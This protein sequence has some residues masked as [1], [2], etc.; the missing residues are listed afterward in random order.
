MLK[1]TVIRDTKST[2]RSKYQ[3]IY[4]QRLLQFDNINKFLDIFRLCNMSKY[5]EIQDA[6]V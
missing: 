5:F 4:S 6:K 3:A 2:Y 1:F